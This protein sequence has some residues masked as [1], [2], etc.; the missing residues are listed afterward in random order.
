VS[1]PG[2]RGHDRSRIFNRHGGTSSGGFRQG[3][4]RI[5]VAIMI[6][7]TGFKTNS[8]FK[9][10]VEQMKGPIEQFSI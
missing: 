1:Q 4:A 7:I 6:L 5:Q 10:P 9:G 3:G 8:Q 2:D